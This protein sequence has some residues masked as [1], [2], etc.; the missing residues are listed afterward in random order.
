MGV[1]QRSGQIFAQLGVRGALQQSL[2]GGHAAL[3]HGRVFGMLQRQI[4]KDAGYLG[5]LLVGA[6]V[7]CLQRQCQGLRV[8]CKALGSVAMD[9]ARELVQQDHQCQLLPWTLGCP[10]LQGTAQ[11]GL[12]SSAKAL[13]QLLVE[14]RRFGEPLRFVPQ[15]IGIAGPGAAEPQAENLVGQAGVLG[16]GCQCLMADGKGICSHANHCACTAASVDSQPWMASDV[17]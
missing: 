17:R 9:I 6:G 11:S 10:V 5:Q 16:G 2:E 7:H 1:V 12:Y 13:A 4:H 15:G 8:T 14:G 3:L